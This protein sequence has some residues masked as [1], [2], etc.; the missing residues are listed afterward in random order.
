MEVYEGNTQGGGFSGTDIYS[1]TESYRISKVAEKGITLE[2]DI[3]GRKM[4][5]TGEPTSFHVQKNVFV[6][7]EGEIVSLPLIDDRLF[8]TWFIPGETRPGAS[9]PAPFQPGFHVRHEN[10]TFAQMGLETK[11]FVG[12]WRTQTGAE[13]ELRPDFT[14][15]SLS[16]VSSEEGRWKLEPPNKLVLQLSTKKEFRITPALGE[17]Q[18]F[19]VPSEGE[20]DIWLRVK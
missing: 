7:Y 14:C 17:K 1:A 19:V 18:L 6:P 4:P 11:E 3:K 16:A 10:E 15:K 20:G 9:T 5:Q 8:R 12:T 13:Y 2:V